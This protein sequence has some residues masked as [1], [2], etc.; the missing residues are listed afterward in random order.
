MSLADK[1]SPHYPKRMGDVIVKKHFTWYVD[2]GKS[3]RVERFSADMTDGYHTTIVS[4]EIRDTE[5]E[6]LRALGV[7]VSLKAELLRRKAEA[8][9]AITDP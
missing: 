3:V 5:G 9:Q 8:L 7:A 1:P 6:A 4:G 2:A